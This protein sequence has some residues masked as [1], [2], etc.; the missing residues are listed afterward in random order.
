MEG[1]DADQVQRLPAGA[2][3]IPADVVARNQRERLVAAVAEACAEKGYAE[4]SVADLAQRA[5]VSTATFYKLFDGKGA[6]ALEAHRELVARL[7]EEV[8]RVCASEGEWEGKVR[9]AVG[10][11]LELFAA[12]APTAR[13]LTVEVLALGPAG[14]ERHGAA[15]EAFASRV[16]AARA[17]GAEE[18]LPGADWT[19]VAGLAALIGRRVMA[20]AAGELPQL[21]DEAV[22]LVL[23]R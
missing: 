6:C 20:G 5:G 9:A 21:E 19:L 13:L 22:A 11:V 8:D 10:T 3:G 7:L 4:T 18:P 12:D 15:I 23:A 2:H 14:A 17:S 16:R 1:A